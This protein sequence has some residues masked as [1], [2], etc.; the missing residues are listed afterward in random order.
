M[1]LSASMTECFALFLGT[2]SHTLSC[3]NCL[4]NLHSSDL[5]LVLIE[6]LRDLNVI[7]YHVRPEFLDI[8]FGYSRVSFLIF[9]CN[10]SF[11]FQSFGKF[12]RSSKSP[13]FVSF[14]L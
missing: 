2:L 4:T 9:T 12:K 6:S 8:F 13:S 14:P 10:V 3:M 11:L 7:R 5:S 1:I